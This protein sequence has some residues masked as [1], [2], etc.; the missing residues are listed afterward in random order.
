MEETQSPQR[1]I[2]SARQD[3]EPKFAPIHR[4]RLCCLGANSG[5][6][7]SCTGSNRHW[8]KH[9]PP[10]MR[11]ICGGLWPTRQ[12]SNLR[13]QESESCAL[14]S[15][16]TGRY[17]WLRTAFIIAHFSPDCKHFLR[18]FRMLCRFFIRHIDKPSVLVYNS[19]IGMLKYRKDEEN[20]DV[21]KYPRTVRLH[22]L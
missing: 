9:N 17:H 2:A 21:K 14:S 1:C 7:E 18:F 10:Q 4:I 8:S 6:T 22:G 15:W 16:A 13:P 3:S 12:D 5:R 19:S 20:C 11:C